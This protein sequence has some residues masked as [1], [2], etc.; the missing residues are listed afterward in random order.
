MTR[1]D[2]R[3]TFDDGYR[4]V[5]P[6]AARHR[7]FTEALEL[8]AEIEPNSFV[9]VEALAEIAG[10]LRVGA[11][12]LLLDVGCG[13]G[14]T[15][16][17]LARRLD[18]RLVGA[19][20]S[21]VAVRQAADRRALF[22][23]AGSARFV[24][25]DQAALGLAGGSAAAVVSI[26]AVQFSAD[27]A[28]AVREAARVLRPGGRYVLTNWEPRDPGHPDVPARMRDLDFARML[29]AAGLLVLRVDERP[30]LM[31]RQEAIFAAALATDPAGDPA[32]E[33]L[34]AEAEAVAGWPPIM[35]RVLA[36]AE[37]PHPR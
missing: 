32:L 9:T 28:A 31:R 3:R 21:T 29:A 34:R 24:V 17:W 26:D 10:A 1:P 16:L 14:G 6:S 22:G 27:P 20:F 11:G 23:L 19:D 25:A 8:P 33:R 15:G 13:R 35:R 7:L 37:K 12:D 36:V 5:G 30:D 18:A 2:L 4:A